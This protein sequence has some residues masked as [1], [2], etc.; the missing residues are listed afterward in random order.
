MVLQGS[1]LLS[2][3]QYNP[4]QAEARPVISRDT[5]QL[6]TLSLFLVRGTPILDGFDKAYLDENAAFIKSLSDL[7]E[8]ESV[9]VGNMTFANGTADDVIAYAR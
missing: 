6:V 5:V 3:L 7:R 1:F 9:Q 4:K 8:K 2:S